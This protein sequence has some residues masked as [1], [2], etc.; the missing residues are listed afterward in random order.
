M[1]LQHCALCIAVQL[2]E[3][4]REVYDSAY[5][6]LRE[7][8]IEAV[9]VFCV[10]ECDVVCVLKACHMRVAYVLFIVFCVDEPYVVCTC[11]VCLFC[12]CGWTLHFHPTT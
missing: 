1:S 9:G 4:C 6:K 11:A 3:S 2:A 7:H 12:A 10:V 8:V 5:K